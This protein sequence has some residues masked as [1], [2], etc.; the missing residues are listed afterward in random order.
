MVRLRTGR[1]GLVP[2]PEEA[3]AYDFSPMEREFVDS[4]NANVIH[5]TADEVRAGLDDLH[6]RTGADELMLTGNAHGGDV[7]LRSYELI[8]DAY[9]LPKA[10]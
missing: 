6:K 9:G 8:A 5:G 1:P 7:R 3:E 2:T 4:W 10:G